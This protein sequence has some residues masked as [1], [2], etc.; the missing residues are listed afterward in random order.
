M[1]VRCP[2]PGDDP[3]MIRYHDREWGVP[4]HRDRKM[5]EFLVLETFQA[6]LSWRTVLHKRRAFRAA[7]ADFDFHRVAKFG[8]REI[9]RLLQ[10]PK[11]IR[12]RQ[13]I[14]ATINNA[15]R[16]LEV[17][18]EY[19]TFSK[20]LWRFVDG[21]PLQNH[22]R[23]LHHLPAVT[24]LAVTVSA[25]LKKRGFQFMGPTVVYAHLQ[26][27]GLVN[28]HLINCFRYRDRSS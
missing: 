24:P 13:K 11:I 17:S 23:K 14:T 16:V 12:N 10:N 4:V 5:F 1:L 15:R 7:F 3:L 18:I 2:W 9:R 22:W 27:A 6:G 21:K 25:D 20:Y 26:A 19:G 28:D 8:E